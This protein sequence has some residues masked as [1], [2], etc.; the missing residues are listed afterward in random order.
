[1][2]K[3]VRDWGIGEVCWHTFHGRCIVKGIPRPPIVGWLGNLSPDLVVI[4]ESDGKELVFNSD[5]VTNGGDPLCNV[6]DLIPIDEWDA[7]K[8]LKRLAEEI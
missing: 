7:S 6:H 1:M 8:E 2:S 4:R 5:H 3:G